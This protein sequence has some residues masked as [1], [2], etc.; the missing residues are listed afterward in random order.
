MLDARSEGKRLEPKLYL[1][2]EPVILALLSTLVILCFGAVGGLSSIYHTQQKNLGRQWFARGAKDLQAA[3]FNRATAEFRTALLYSRDNDSYQLDLAQ[4]LIGQKKTEEASAYLNNLWEREPEN[5]FVNL[6]LARIAAQKGEA[7]R[8]LRYYHNAIYAT[9]PADR[10]GARQQARLE[11]IDYLLRIDDKPQAQ[12][13]LIALA[14]NLGD[15]PSRQAHLGD[16]FIQA[17]DYRDALAAY[18][19]SFKASPDNPAALAGAGRAALELGR[20]RQAQQYLH[21][22]VA[23]GARDPEVADQLKTADLV[24][25]MDPFRR[26]I[27][28]AER[29]RIV[30]EAFTA[31]GQRLDACMAAEGD[32]SSLLVQQN[33]SERWTKMKPRITARGLRQDTDLAES[34]MELAFS[35]ERETS[36]TCE[37]PGATDRALLLIARLHEGN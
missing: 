17:Q 36:V 21:A 5:G 20:Y 1:T 27:R 31:A 25:R 12:S 29:A 30:T 13:E 18:R 2:K 23:A 19:L 14:A 35:I 15:D 10:Q 37:R 7:E 26:Q 32:G 28:A 6:E 16:L 22:A 34:A 9:W 3:R 33:L 8:A 11:L 24:L 4:A